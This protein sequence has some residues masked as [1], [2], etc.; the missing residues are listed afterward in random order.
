MPSNDNS[1]NK[2]HFLGIGGTGMVAVA[3]LAIE[4][5]WEVRGSDN[6]LYPPTSHMVQALNISVAEGYTAANLD[7]DNDV[8]LRDFVRFQIAI[9]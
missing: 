7:C 5:G 9:P 4:A 2:V 8:D 1:A 3:R 6:P